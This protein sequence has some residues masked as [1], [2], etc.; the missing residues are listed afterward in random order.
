MKEKFVPDKSNC[1]LF[2]I[3]FIGISCNHYKKVNRLWIRIAYHFYLSCE[4]NLCILW[5]LLLDHYKGLIHESR[6]LRSKLVL[7]MI[8]IRRVTSQNENKTMWPWET[9]S[10]SKSFLIFIFILSFDVSIKQEDLYSILLNWRDLGV[11]FINA[12]N[13]IHGLLDLINSRCAV[14]TIEIPHIKS[15][16]NTS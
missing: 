1:C 14:V 6:Y 8:H 3:V 15:T 11:E 2:N 10:W 9:I 5:Y 13:N 16:N 7:S 4:Q 12:N